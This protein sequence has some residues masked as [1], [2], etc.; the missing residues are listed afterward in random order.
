[1]NP[2]T[3]LGLFS[4]A[5][6]AGAL[7][8]FV[9][10]PRWKQKYSVSMNDRIGTCYKDLPYGEG[11]YNKFDLYLPAQSRKD[12]FGLVIY[13]HAGGFTTGDKADDASML[14]WLCSKGY[15]AAGINYTLCSEKNPDASVMSQS[16]EIRLAVPKVVEAA[17]KAG[18][19]I[20]RIAAG[21]GS[22]G[23]TLAMIYAFRDGLNAPRPV[24]LTFGAVG[25]ASFLQED[26]GI[27]GLDESDEACAALFSAMAGQRISPSEIADGSYCEKMKPISASDWVSK[28]P[29]PCIAAYGAHD[30]IQ[31]FKASSHLRK[32]LA[33]CGA[34]FRF[35]EFP[36]SGHGLQNDDVQFK[37]WM[38]S[39]EEYLEKYLP[40][41]SK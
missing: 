21:G 40:V 2:G 17:E 1:M 37:K 18:Y 16:E 36:H 10:K 39:I 12:H 28:N 3:W 6:A 30:R 33:E 13:L 25:P 11:P 9:M 14:A 29:V 31:P 26:W 35:I 38:E 15:A 23:H 7:S 34:D 19:P 27:F 4:A 24:V 32:A 20:D 8:R 22:A 41:S 5:L